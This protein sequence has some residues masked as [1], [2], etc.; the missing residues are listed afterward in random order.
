VGLVTLG[1]LLCT[2]FL[3]APIRTEEPIDVSRLTGPRKN[4]S[5]D[6]SLPALSGDS[7]GLLGSTVSHG[8]HHVANVS[9]DNQGLGKG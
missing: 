5:F 3:M 8:D 9:R 4:T 7:R 1:M 2:H 6:R